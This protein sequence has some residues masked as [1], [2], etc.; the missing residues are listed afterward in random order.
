MCD[1]LKWTVLKKENLI[2]TSY[3]FDLVKNLCTKAYINKCW[4]KKYDGA[5]KNQLNDTR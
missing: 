3:S 4:L 1:K 2:K 5:V